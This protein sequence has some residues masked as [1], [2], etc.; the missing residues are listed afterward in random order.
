[1]NRSCLI[2]A[3][4]AVWA[5]GPSPAASVPEMNLEHLVERSPRIVHGTVARS[6]TAW[7]ASR[8]FLWTHYELS[9]LEALRGLPEAEL[10]VSVP[11]GELD[12]M[13]MQV[14]GVTRFA[15]GEE[16][17][18]FA[19]QTPNGLMRVRGLGQGKYSVSNGSLGARTVSA[20]LEGLRLLSAGK[21]AKGPATQ[22]A[23][24]PRT[25]EGFL[26]TV[27]TLVAKEVR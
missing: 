26:S 12:G 21:P 1:M 4:I 24:S 18:V 23:E 9:L 11:G 25:L 14:P 20:D 3:L 6:W 16:V 8:R 5:A 7:D 13:T 17:V 27:R 19:Y 15:V 22:G 2:V 10:I